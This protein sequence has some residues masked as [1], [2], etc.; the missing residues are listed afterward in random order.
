MGSLGQREQKEKE[1]YNRRRSRHQL[2]TNIKQREN[3]QKIK[4]D[5]NPKEAKG[6]NSITPFGITAREG[7]EVSSYPLISSFLPSSPLSF[8]FPLFSSFFFFTFFLLVCCL[9]RYISL[10]SPMAVGEILRILLLMLVTHHLNEKKGKNETGIV[11]KP[12]T[13]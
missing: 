4:R 2:H 3:T 8:S 11:V 10:V 1:Q 6:A 7:G 12:K 9:I 13:K 5:S